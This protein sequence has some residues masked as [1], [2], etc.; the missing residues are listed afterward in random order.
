MGFSSVA[1]VIAPYVL[2][3]VPAALRNRR[4]PLAVKRPVARIARRSSV[5]HPSLQPE[6]DLAFVLG[7]LILGP[8]SWILSCSLVRDTTYFSYKVSYDTAFPCEL[9]F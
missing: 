3:T 4:R 5:L 8:L 7:A 2:H 6:Q 1:A 9:R